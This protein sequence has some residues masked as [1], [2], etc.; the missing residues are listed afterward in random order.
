[1][2]GRSADAGDDVLALGVDEVL[3]HEL[4]LAGGGVA[5]EGDAGARTHAR[6]AER[7]LLDVDG[8]APFVG[9][10]VHLAVDVGARVIPGAEDGLD[11][12]D[13]LLFGVLREF[14]ALLFKVDRLEPLNEFPSYHRR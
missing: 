8:G 12:A 2:G 11:G 13:Q 9:D 7:H 4:L 10:L 14:G 5:G 6:V 1:M 3:A